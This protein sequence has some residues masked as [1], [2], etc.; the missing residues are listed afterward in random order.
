M[1]SIFKYIKDKVLVCADSE[2]HPECDVCGKSNVA[3]YETMGFPIRDDG[4]IDDDDEVVVACV[5]CFSAGKVARMGEASIEEFLKRNYPNWKQL[6]LELRKTPQIPYCA[7]EDDWAICCNDLCEFIGVPESFDDLLNFIDSATY[8]TRGND[9][10]VRDF[11]QDGP[12]ESLNEIS[13]FQCLEC[14]RQ[15]WIDQ[16]T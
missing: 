12:P 2:I 13:K 14:K 5:A 7:Q 16:F 11:R 8:W 10:F 4:T 3:V 1:G 15:Y 6:L 9:A